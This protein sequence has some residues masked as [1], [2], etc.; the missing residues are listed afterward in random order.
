MDLCKLF[1][2]KGAFIQSNYSQEAKPVS[3][4]MLIIIL[5]NIALVIL[6]AACLTG[7][8]LYVLLKKTSFQTI[9]TPTMETYMAPSTSA[10]FCYNGNTLAMYNVTNCSSVTNEFS[11]YVTNA[12]ASGQ[13]Q[14][15]IVSA[16]RDFCDTYF[17]SSSVLLRKIEYN[18][19]LQKEL[20]KV[21]VWNNCVAIDV[22]RLLWQERIE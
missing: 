6:F 20:N 5:L 2:F 15:N 1:F 12:K 17:F 16:M 13:L 21:I 4:N 22:P 10:M 9:D 14:G 19:V 11:V 3:R 18:Q 8:I 7:I